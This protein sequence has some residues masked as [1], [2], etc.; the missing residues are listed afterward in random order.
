MTITGGSGTSSIT[1]GITHPID[2]ASGNQVSVSFTT[3][4]GGS[5]TLNFTVSCN[6]YTKLTASYCGA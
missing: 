2:F 6:E 4:C 3:A 1:V 5:K